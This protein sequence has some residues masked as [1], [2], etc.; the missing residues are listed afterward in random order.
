MA[1]PSA[2]GPLSRIGG[3]ALGLGYLPLSPLP[4][5]IAELRRAKPADYWE[6]V[7]T[8]WAVPAWILVLL[9]LRWRE[10]LFLFLPA[11]MAWRC[12]RA[13]S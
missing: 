12:S 10:T 2:S 4:P 9:V 1:R 3:G 7:A 8:R 11:T 6:I 5:Y 13:S